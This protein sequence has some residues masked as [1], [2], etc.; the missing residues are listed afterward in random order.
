MIEGKEDK[1]NDY[2]MF[3]LY[4]V[5]YSGKTQE[6][7]IDALL[8]LEGSSINGGFK[9]SNDFDEF[10]KVEWQDAKQFSFND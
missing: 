8:T 1:Q 7:P 6:E 2:S 4:D 5:F 10:Y 9:V 3:N